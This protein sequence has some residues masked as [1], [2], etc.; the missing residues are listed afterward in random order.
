MVK[1]EPRRSP[2]EV[3]GIA[4]DADA[5]AIK[6]AYFERI[7]QNPPETHPEVFKQLREAYELLSDPEARQAYDASAAAQAE[8][9]T[10]EEDARL[11]EA[12]DLFDAGDTAGG[13]SVLNR[14]LLEQPDFHQARLLLGRSFL[15]EEAPE[16]A[17]TEFDEVLK[18]APEDWR[19]HLHR[20]WALN[21]LTRL[22]EAADAYWRAG[23]YGPAE[24]GPRVSLADCLV[25]MGQ[26]DDALKVLLEAQALPGIP[27][28]E[29][30]WFKMRRIAMLLEHD[31]E[32][33]ATRGL[34]EL[35]AEVPASADPELRRWMAAQVSA[36]A[37]HLFAQRKSQA[38]NRL[39]E[40]GRR[41]HPDDA[42]AAELSFPNGVH[43]DISALP[44]AGRQWVHAGA[45]D[46]EGWRSQWS[47]AMPAAVTFAL[48][49]ATFFFLAYCAFGTGERS[50]YNWSGCVVMAAAL[51]A[52]TAYAARRFLT[53]MTQPYGRFTL[54]H[55]LHLV[56]V[57]GDHVIVWPLVHLE[58]VQLVN[59]HSHVSYTHTLIEMRFNGR[60][61]VTFGH[62]ERAAKDFVAQL[63]AQR[64]RVLELLSQG[65]LSAEEGMAQLPAELLARGASSGTVHGP[66]H[67][68]PHATHPLVAAGLGVLLV[69]AAVI[70]HRSAT[71][72][73][74]W[75]HAAV[76]TSGLGPLLTFLRARPDSH[77]SVQ[78]Q[79]RVD[80]ELARVR[81]RLESRLDPGSAAAR[82]VPF[83]TGLL[84]DVSRTHSRRV[85]VEWAEPAS[86]KGQGQA[87]ED[88]SILLVSAWQRLLDEA[89]GRDVLVVDAGRNS[90]EG[91][92]VLTLQV[93]EALRPSTGSG[94]VRHRVWQVRAKGPGGED[95]VAPLELTAD[96]ADPK[97]PE[98]LFHAWVDQ[99]HLPGAGDR[100]P[101]LL[102]ASTLVRSATP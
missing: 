11:K 13:R 102:T 38:A 68:L 93:G 60:Q 89:L 51:C 29:V 63:V 20:G 82:S 91:P 79:A 44:E 59:Q 69:V 92:P 84:N 83:F 4:V 31:R 57:M 70:P 24:V 71:D 81:A 53:V 48:A 49:L 35:D 80:A 94:P 5:R 77:F 61:V 87:Q 66:P 43:V 99:W 34:D 7:R 37:A 74:A 65:L 90:Q 56:E 3:L 15:W 95:I 67:R 75:Q 55:P 17:L 21:R 50:F 40:Y 58:D 18:R 76:Q 88:L 42:P 64:R 19:G 86:E 30:L 39:L 47:W 62:S 6:K 27:R 98:S 22:K 25:E 72:A 45:E 97:V 1:D 2:Y 78:A 14:M 100:R 28:T 52:A 10:S 26:V 23:K 33:E 8:G 36:A 12:V 96:A 73:Q 85:V 32:R 9:G 16:A 101:L 41:F 46:S 54:L